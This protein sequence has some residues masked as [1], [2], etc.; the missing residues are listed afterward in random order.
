MTE[1]SNYAL[2]LAHA[3]VNDS[4]Y[5]HTR[6]RIS[7]SH[8]CLPG[9]DLQIARRCELQVADVTLV[10]FLFSVV[11]PAVEHQLALLS[12]AFVAQFTFV[13]LLPYGK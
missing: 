6:T 3:G 2:T 1:F 10:R 5:F 8:A 13:W 11:H 7:G 12:K 9:V 4:V